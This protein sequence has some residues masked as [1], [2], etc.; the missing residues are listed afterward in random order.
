M[1][2]RLLSSSSTQ[3]T[4][5]IMDKN[6]SNLAPLGR[7]ILRGTCR[8]SGDSPVAGRY[9]CDG[10]LSNL[11]SEMTVPASGERATRPSSP[12]SMRI[13]PA[14]SRRNLR[15]CNSSVD[16]LARACCVIAIGGFSSA[17]HSASQGIEGQK[18]RVC[19]NPVEARIWLG[20]GRCPAPTQRSCED[21]IQGWKSGISRGKH[22]A[23]FDSGSPGDWR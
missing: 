9:R 22:R 4:N 17:A 20:M 23:H 18:P 14:Q 1:T 7:T 12:L 11:D 15:R 16:W 10:H 21:L 2:A 6:P 5:K 13:E 8:H 3:K 19:G